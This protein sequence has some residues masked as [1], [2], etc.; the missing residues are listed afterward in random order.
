MFLCNSYFNILYLMFKVKCKDIWL[1]WH[2]PDDFV[3]NF[4]H[5]HNLF[6]AFIIDFEQVIVSCAFSTYVSNKRK[7]IK[8]AFNE[9][10]STKTVRA[11]YK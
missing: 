8:S 11:H 1:Q 5:N 7:S 6:C 9:R 3:V 2:R 10:N 4:E